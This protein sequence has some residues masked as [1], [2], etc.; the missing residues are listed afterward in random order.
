[1]KTRILFNKDSSK[2]RKKIH[3][4]NVETNSDISEMIMTF[5]KCIANTAS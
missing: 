5:I 3:G 2:N 4:K 1:M